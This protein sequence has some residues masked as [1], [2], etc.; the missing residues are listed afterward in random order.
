MSVEA[1]L[2]AA[3]AAM[4]AAGGL[5]L[6]RLARHTHERSSRF[7]T[8][9][10]SFRADLD[11]WECPEGEYLHRI[12]LDHTARVVRYRARAAVCNA[13]PAK[14]GCTDSD[15]GREVTRALDPWP[16]SESG[17]FHRAISFVMV[18]LA[19]LVCLVAMLRNTAPPELLLLGSGLRCPD[20]GEAGRPAARHGVRLPRRS[21]SGRAPA[22]RPRR[23]AFLSR[24]APGLSPPR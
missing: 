20:R 23:R 8:N 18:A 11:A 24:A 17:R 6:D 9:G 4:L 7:R 14:D 16:R 12:D 5:V 15:E 22:G 21:G 3:Y 19:A 10:F 2:A 1:L 13:C